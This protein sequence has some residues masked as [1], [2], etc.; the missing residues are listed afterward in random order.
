MLIT[1]AAHG[2]KQPI[3]KFLRMLHRGTP[4]A[5]QKAYKLSQ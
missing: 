1:V 5:L 2:N 4:E 3:Q